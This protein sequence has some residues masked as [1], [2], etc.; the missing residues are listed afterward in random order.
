MEVVKQH[1][2][3]DLSSNNNFVTVPSM[4]GDG[5]EVRY[6]EL[7]LISYGTRFEVDPEDVT[8]TIMGTKADGT[9]IFNRCEI[10]EEGYILV[11]ITQQMSTAV[12][13][14]NYQ[15]ALFS[16][17]KNSQIKSFPF[18]ILVTASPFDMDKM[19][20]QD[21]YQ[22]LSNL[23]T[24]YKKYAEEAAASAEA[25]AQ[26]AQDAENAAT[27]AASDA[28]DAVRTEML[29]YVNSASS[30]EANAH[31]SEVNASS[32][33]ANA[34]TSE[35][36]AAMSETNAALSEASAADS[37]TLS[38]SWAI[39]GTNTREGE[40]T[41]NSKYYAEQAQASLEAINSGF[42]RFAVENGH[43]LWEPVTP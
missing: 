29:G 16:R 26:S 3:I 6:A 34:K 22:E 2:T 7:E 25:A 12:G 36:N 21:E 8:A 32:S 28:V 5:A 20:S 27:T 19:R 23:E 4:Q 18:Q 31:M 1:Y 24:E 42:I 35:Q 38:E 39:G 40:D 15:I 41:N 11:E 10:T 17:S 43:L 13:R 14:G 33:E 30:S 9:Q 37:A